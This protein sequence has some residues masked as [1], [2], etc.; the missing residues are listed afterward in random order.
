LRAAYLVAEPPAGEPIPVSAIPI[1]QEHLDV[2]VARDAL[3][4]LVA[5]SSVICALVGVLTY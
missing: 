3:D 5:L 1:I 2:L 4:L